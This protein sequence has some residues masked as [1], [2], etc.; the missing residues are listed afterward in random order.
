MKTSL[1]LLSLLFSTEALCQIP[2]YPL[3]V[4]DRWDYHTGRVI[5]IIGDTLLPNGHQ[6]AIVRDSDLPTASIFARQESTKVYYFRPPDDSAER[7]Q[8]D[9][10]LKLRDTV[11]LDSAGFYETVFTTMP[12]TVFGTERSVMEFDECRY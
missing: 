12:D 11:Y 10:G 8:Y 7:V 9:F 3:G 5:E 4:G 6:Y 2:Y 1:L